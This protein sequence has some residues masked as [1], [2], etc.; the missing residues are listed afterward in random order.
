MVVAFSKATLHRHS[1]ERLRRLLSALS[2][3]LLMRMLLLVLLA[4]AYDEKSQHHS[5]SVAVV[6]FSLP[7]EATCVVANDECRL[8]SYHPERAVVFEVII[9]PKRYNI[10]C[11]KV[12][13]PHAR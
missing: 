1:C 12:H 2:L 7:A 3:L 8:M 9:G 5:A 11:N 10:S 13:L 4:C 6:V